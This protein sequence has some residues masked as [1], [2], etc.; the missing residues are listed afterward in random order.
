MADKTISITVVDTYFDK[1]VSLEISKYNGMVDLFHTYA[2]LSNE[3]MRNL[4]FFHDGVRLSNLETPLDLSLCCDDEVLIL[5]LV[6]SLTST[7]IDMVILRYSWNDFAT[8]E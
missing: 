8:V 7:S 3:S 6:K 4:R 5:F 1:R 2:T